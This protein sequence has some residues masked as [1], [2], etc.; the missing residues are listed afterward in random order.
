MPVLACQ[1]YDCQAHAERVDPLDV[2][3][4][5]TSRLQACEECDTPDSCRSTRSRSF[6]NCFMIED[7]S[8][9]SPSLRSNSRQIAYWLG[10]F[11]I[12]SFFVN[13]SH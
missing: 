11:C 4:L 1:N 2:E 12:C 9:M 8:A 13:A 3:E 7:T 5:P 10:G 6:F